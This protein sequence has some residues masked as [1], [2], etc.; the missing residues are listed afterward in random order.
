[1][2]R[3][4]QRWQTLRSVARSLRIYYGDRGHRNAMRI[5]YGRFIRPDDLVFDIGAHVGDRIAAFRRLGARVVAV[6]PQPA[7]VTT[8]RILYGRD[9]AVTIEPIAL[10]SSPGTLQLQLNLDNPTVA[11]GSHAFVQAAYGAPG[12]EGEKWTK[13]IDVPAITVDALIERH[14]KPAF[15]KLDVEGLEADVIAGLSYAVPALSF[16]FTTLLP[17]VARSCVLRCANLGYARYNA[18]LGEKHSFVHSEWLTSSEI[19]AWLSSLPLE[20]NSGDIYAIHESGIRNRGSD[21]S[22]Q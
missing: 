16:E 13:T 19:A 14:G 17:Q 1:M 4:R 15:I 6:E 11:T 2:K 10:A 18:I 3:L 20:A 5:L 12:W 8:L 7:L 21:A 22:S 9:R